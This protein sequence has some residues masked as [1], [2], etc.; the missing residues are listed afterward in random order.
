M[1]YDWG[2][3][4]IDQ[5]LLACG[6]REPSEVFCQLSHVTESEVDDGFTLTLG[7]PGGLRALIE[8]GTCNY[9]SLPRFYV[10]GRRGTAL[11]NDWRE[12]CQ[13]TQCFRWEEQA[14]L[15]SAEESAEARIMTPRDG[16]SVRQFSLERPQADPHAALRNFCQAAEGKTALAVRRDEVMSVVRVI[17]AAFASEEQKRPVDLCGNPL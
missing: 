7:F 15:N 11:I 6:G 3:H 10:C 14:D 8:V 1:L 2:P 12:N 16:Q 13:V 5:I 9:I 4:L 17:R